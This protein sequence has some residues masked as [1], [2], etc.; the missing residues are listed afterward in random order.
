MWK[1]SFSVRKSIDK[2]DNRMQE[3]NICLDFQENYAQIRSKMKSMNLNT[4][5]RWVQLSEHN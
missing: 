5:E 4:P 3:L 1:V 2:P